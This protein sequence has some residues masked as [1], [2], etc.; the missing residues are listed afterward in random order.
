VCAQTELEEHAT[1]VAS[2]EDQVKRLSSEL[3]SVQDQLRREK[4]RVTQ[5]DKQRAGYEGQVSLIRE[6]VGYN[7]ETAH[8]WSRPKELQ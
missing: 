7:I 2:A 8:H 6:S 4:D 3:S 5:V 1:D